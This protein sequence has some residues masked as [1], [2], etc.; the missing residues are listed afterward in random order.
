MA[1]FPREILLKIGEMACESE[2]NAYETVTFKKSTTP[3]RLFA[4][5]TPV[6][7]GPCSFES[8]CNTCSMFARLGIARHTDVVGAG[9]MTHHDYIKAVLKKHKWNFTHVR[10]YYPHEPPL[11]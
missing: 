6:H 3:A 10:I 9:L 1:L 7:G 11:C 5:Q 4:A 2:G 8:P